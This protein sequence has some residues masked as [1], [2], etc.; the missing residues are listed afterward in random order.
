MRDA[1]MSRA[2]GVLMKRSDLKF[3]QAE[4]SCVHTIVTVMCSWRE[5]R[6]AFIKPVLD[7]F[8]DT[9]SIIRVLKSP[10][11]H[12]GI[13]RIGR[14]HSIVSIPKPEEIESSL[15]PPFRSV[16]GAE[17]QSGPVKLGRT[18]HNDLCPFSTS[19]HSRAPNPDRP[20][21]TVGNDYLAGR[22]KQ[23]NNARKKL[24]FV[25][26]VIC[27]VWVGRLGNRDRPSHRQS[28]DRNACDLPGG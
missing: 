17:Y 15:S 10:C 3:S 26:Y 5:C 13:R 28:P 8:S 9:I 11:F 2:R 14:K 6:V 23:G 1:S 7:S 21:I 20:T 4:T 18:Q 25:I 22:A 19:K 12:V 24:P 16:P 27:L